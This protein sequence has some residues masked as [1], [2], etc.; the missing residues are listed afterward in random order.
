MFLPV[1]WNV[2]RDFDSLE[3]VMYLESW[4]VGAVKLVTPHLRGKNT[5]G[6]IIELRLHILLTFRGL[7][8]GTV[9]LILFFYHP[10]TN[11]AEKLTLSLLL[12]YSHYRLAHLFLCVSLRRGLDL[13]SGLPLCKVGVVTTVSPPLPWGLQEIMKGKCSTHGK[14][15]VNVSC[16]CF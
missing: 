12:S 11:R 3:P 4:N 15:S 6:Y 7:G 10:N 13:G 1:S 14:T 5:C 2:S 8:L 9:C 16:W